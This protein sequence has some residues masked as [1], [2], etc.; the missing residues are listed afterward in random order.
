M[1]GQRYSLATFQR[2]A[3]Q[4]DAFGQRAY[5]NDKDWADALI[6]WPCQRLDQSGAESTRGSQTTATE[7]LQFEGDPYP[8]ITEGIDTTCRIVCD[9]VRYAITAIH[10]MNV[11]SLSCHVI[12]SVETQ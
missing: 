8:L 12:A 3:G 1:I 7:T 5:Q 9:G 10:G 2:F 4:V 11:T 6:D